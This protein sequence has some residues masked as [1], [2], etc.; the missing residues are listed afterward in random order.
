[1]MVKHPDFRTFLPSKVTKY[2]DEYF[3]NRLEKSRLNIYLDPVYRRV[4][5]L[6][7]FRGVEGVS[8]DN[9]IDCYDRA[10]VE[11]N[12]RHPKRRD[13]E[14]QRNYRVGIDPA[15]HYEQYDWVKD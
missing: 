9:V 11:Y 4:D 15:A 10:M 12:S 1:M 5:A 7:E 6:S 8:V 14:G 13:N 3:L 2:L